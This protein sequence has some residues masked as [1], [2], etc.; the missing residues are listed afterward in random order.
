M[1]VL[2]SWWGSSDVQLQ[3]LVRNEEHV[4]TFILC[5]SIKTSIFTF[6]DKMKSLAN[7]IT[8]TPSLLYMSHN[9]MDLVQTNIKMIYTKL[10]YLFELMFLTILLKYTITFSLMA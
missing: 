6:I 9:K 10:L 1:A 3:G 7:T 2:G 8:C 5:C 4:G